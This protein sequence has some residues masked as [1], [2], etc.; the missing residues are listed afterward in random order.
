MHENAKKW[1]THC[2]MLIRKISTDLALIISFELE[3]CKLCCT[4]SVIVYKK[5]DEWSLSDEKWQR[6]LQRVTTNDNEWYKEWQRVTTVAVNGNEW[7]RVTAVVQR[8]KTAQY[9]SKNGWLLSFQW[10]KQI[11]YYFKDG[12]L[13]LE[14]LNKQTF[15]K[16]FQESNWQIAV[17]IK[18]LISS[19]CQKLSV[20]YNPWKNG[21]LQPL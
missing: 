8:M 19:C 7:Q 17:L 6:V 11:H 13:Q 5:T 18:V 12:W 20:L 1:R 4:F 3:N 16:V 14:R 15:L 9:T 2:K 21:W 10:Q